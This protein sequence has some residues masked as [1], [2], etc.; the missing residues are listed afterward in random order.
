[1]TIVLSLIK[2][3]LQI[4]EVP[5]SCRSSDQIIR[6]FLNFFFELEEKSQVVSIPQ[7]AYFDF[8]AIGEAAIAI[9]YRYYLLS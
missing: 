4:R 2:L 1:V 6:K 8:L 9:N 3:S 5:T 7:T